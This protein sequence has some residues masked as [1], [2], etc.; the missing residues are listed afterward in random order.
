MC[1]NGEW[2]SMSRGGSFQ[3]RSLW[4]EMLWRKEDTFVGEQVYGR[5]KP[6]R[7]VS[8]LCSSREKQRNFLQSLPHDPP[9][10]HPLAK[11]HFP[12]LMEEV[13]LNKDSYKPIRKMNR[14]N[15]KCV[16]NYCNRKN[17]SADQNTLPPS[18]SKAE[19]SIA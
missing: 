13:P 8:G 3:K 2:V 19:I 6:K 12:P 10:S 4:G 15:T 9:Q 11:P 16:Q 18:D 5:K 17:F 1:K 14:E 7:E